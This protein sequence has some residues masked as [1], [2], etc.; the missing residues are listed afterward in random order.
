M[1][2]E[3]WYA[4]HQGKPILVGTSDVSLSGQCFMV[5][6]SY[7]NEVQGLPYVY[8]K[9]AINLWD[10]FAALGLDKD[11]VQITDGSVK[12]GDFVIYS[13]SLV[14]NGHVDVAVQDGN[15]SDYVGY[16]SN[17]DK[18]NYHD[19]NG[20]PTLHQVLHNSSLNKFILGSL[21]LKGDEMPADYIVNDGDIE[22][23]FV[24]FLGRKP[25]QQDL[26]IYRGKTHKEI[27][28]AIMNSDEYKSKQTGNYIPVTEQL[29][30]KG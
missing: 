27:A 13:E 18:A 24:G 2:P 20:Y 7:R 29:F 3:Q 25:T 12:T 22:N 19:A 9:G 16:D 14:L 8:A 26:D 11:Y 1:N 28:Y 4:N 6:D 17:W 5:F 15:V 10:D 21:R 30:K 23:Y